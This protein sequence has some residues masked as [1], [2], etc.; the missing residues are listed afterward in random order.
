MQAKRTQ[1]R[2][3]VQVLVF[4]CAARCFVA[5]RE[6]TQVGSCGGKQLQGY[7][8]LPATSFGRVADTSHCPRY[9]PEVPAALCL[10]LR[11]VQPRIEQ[12]AQKIGPPL[13]R[14]MLR[15][16]WWVLQVMV[17]R[18]EAFARKQQ[19]IKAALEIG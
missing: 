14:R 8:C 9:T 13:A 17:M 11:C 15:E 2:G 10:G 12:E 16:V 4:G 3:A 6:L 1:L 18:R 19:A 7:R 5:W